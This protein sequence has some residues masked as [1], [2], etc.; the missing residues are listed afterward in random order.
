MGFEPG[1]PECRANDLPLDHGTPSRVL[2]YC[3]FIE[4]KDKR[5]VFVNAETH[6]HE[7]LI[8]A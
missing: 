5:R 8:F 7:K 4:K 2:I 6:K 1:L 3:L